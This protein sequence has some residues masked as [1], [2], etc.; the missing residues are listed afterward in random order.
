MIDLGAA[1]LVAAAIA[2]A[3]AAGAALLGAH[4]RDRR[5]VDSSR[6][7]VYAL[8]AL[9]SVCV[10]VLE[11]AFLRSDF[12]VEL[13]ASHSSTTT[14]DFY[15]LTAMWGSQGGSLLLWA[16]VLSIAASGVLYATR[17]RHRELVP[18]ATAVL[19]GIGLFFCC[20]MLF[21]DGANPF[22]RLD[23]APAEGAGLN[24]LLRHWAMAIHPP[25]L[26]SGYVLF[27]IPFA[28]AIGA[29]VARRLDASWIRST[30]RFALLAWTFLGTGLLLG[31]LWS[32]EELGWGGYWGWD[33]VENAALMPWLVGTAFLHSVMVQEKRGMLRVWN[34]S[35][36][37]AAFALALL[38]TFLVRSGILQSI[39]AFGDSTVGGP[40]LGLI[41]VVVIGSAALIVSRL[42]ALRGERRIESLASRESVFL[43]NNLLLIGLVAVIFWGTFFPL[44]SEAVTGE[45]SSLGSPWFDRY[46]AP[47]AIL[48]VL[49]TGLGPLFAWRSLSRGALWRLVRTPAA[50]AATVTVALAALTDALSEP[51]ALA[52]FCFAAFSLAALSQEVLRGASA[53]RALSGGSF[54]AALA[55][56][57]AR[58]RRRYGGYVVHAGIAILL[59]AVAA[60][61]SFQ[62]SVDARLLPGESAEVGELTVTYREPTAEID[63]VEQ[64]L[65]FGAVLD[66]S[67]DGR[68][69]STLRP[70]RN[71][72]SGRGDGSAGPL[73]SFFEGEATS[74]VGRRAGPGGDLW[75]AM[76]P[77]LTPLDEVLTR[78]DR[79]LERSVPE[80]GPAGPGPAELEAMRAYAAA[81][82]DAIENFASLYLA[83][84][85]PVDFRVNLNPLVIW[86]W[87]GGAIAVAGALFALWP[88]PAA[89]RRRVSE[90]RAARL[91]RELGRA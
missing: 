84:P 21:A 74:E 53:Q 35:L 43:V 38:G 56:L 41:A 44:I 6:R 67:E 85:L 7:A 4:R 39:H 55:R 26:Y 57:V 28:F 24:P 20:L 17:H 30:R 16:F 5:L 86:V 9:L 22:A 77:D 15:K 90:L 78:V 65:T 47:L 36:I 58:N 83:R 19:A 34:V 61:S 13:V 23:P 12:S 14:P 1:C 89:A 81:Q 32:Y 29:L 68:P 71:Y 8:C 27:A 72:Y 33:A 79:E 70:S 88:A 2:C 73:R 82:G 76:R 69:V 91:A 62:T 3:Y 64:K 40:L 59:I 54:P 63:P 66:V 45:R 49:F 10:V 51:L 87:I 11:A 80:I 60:S 50:I 52:M 25:M 37:V 31:S 75:T 46:T 42:D 18:Y 48:L